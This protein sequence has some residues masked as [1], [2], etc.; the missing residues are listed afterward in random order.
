MVVKLE[1]GGRIDRDVLIKGLVEQQ[2]RRNDSFFAAAPSAS[3]AR[4][5]ISGPRTSRI[6]LGA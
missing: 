6:A 3:A 2:Y 1:R 4:R 5:S